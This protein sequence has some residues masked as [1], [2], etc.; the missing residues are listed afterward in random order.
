MKKI[1]RDNLKFILFVLV[2]WA[3]TFPLVYFKRHTIYN[4]YSIKMSPLGYNPK[5]MGKFIREADSILA[6]N[7]DDNIDTIIRSFPTKEKQKEMKKEDKRKTLLTIEGHLGIMERSCQFVKEK[8]NRDDTLSVLNWRQKYTD[9]ASNQENTAGGIGNTIDR[10]PLPDPMNPVEYWKSNENEI[11]RALDYYKRALNYAGP[12]IIAADKIR[13]VAR[14][15]CKNDEVILAYSTY[16]NGAE[17]HVEK[18]VEERAYDMN[19]GSFWDRIVR[20]FTFKS[21][22]NKDDLYGLTPLMKKQLVWAEIK[23]NKDLKPEAQEEPK[24]MDYLRG[25]TIL[26]SDTNLKKVSPREAAE[27]Y[28]TVL[29]FLQNTTDPIQ[30]K[31]ERFYR[32]KRGKHLYGMGDYAGALLDF[33]AAADFKDLDKESS[34]DIRQV[35]THIF[36]SELYAVK[37]YYQLGKSD[38]NN[39]KYFK[40][41]LSMIDE[42]NNRLSNNGYIANEADLMDDFKEV[43]RNTLKKLGHFQEADEIE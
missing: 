8:E 11:M 3:V 13:P 10:I 33:K 41:A 22:P 29:F 12:E 15:L 24:L 27:L 39:K 2:I 42:L 43:K 40:K 5:V 7:L 20:F 25:I 17:A 9:W 28:E 32:L 19:K 36:E 37:C 6:S 4:W 18:K 34:S 16:V 30:M 26:L 31:N 23:R 35:M 21:I 14:A 38:K 1:I